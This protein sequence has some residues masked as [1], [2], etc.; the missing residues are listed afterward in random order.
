M[1]ILLAVIFLLPFL[2]A[3][4][5]MNLNIIGWLLAWPVDFILNL[6]LSLTGHA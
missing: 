2:G 6:V 4:L 3:Q 1:L 5:G